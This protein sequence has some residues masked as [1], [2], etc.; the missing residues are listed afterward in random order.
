[1]GAL[2]VQGRW[3]KRLPFPYNQFPLQSQIVLFGMDV[4]LLWLGDDKREQKH[5]EVERRTAQLQ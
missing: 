1:M 4:V 2:C 5:E 3:S